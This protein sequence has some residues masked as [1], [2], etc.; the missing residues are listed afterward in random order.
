MLA[1]TSEDALF[2]W[3]FTPANEQLVV[4]W[5]FWLAIAGLILTVLG[6]GLTLMQVTRA[7][8]ASEAAS[9]EVERIRESL[10]RYDAALEVARATYAL[11]SARRHLRNDA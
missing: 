8:S 4:G 6:F 9:D 10:I 7:K 2:N 1:T 11:D 5:G 3:P